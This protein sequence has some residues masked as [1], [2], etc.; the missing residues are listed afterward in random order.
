[1]LIFAPLSLSDASDKWF[2][3]QTDKENELSYINLFALIKQE[4]TG[5]MKR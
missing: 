2:E 5:K 4:T 3:F 1:M